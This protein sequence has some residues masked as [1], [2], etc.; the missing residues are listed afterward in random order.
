MEI[1]I[2]VNVLEPSI[3]K[4]LDEIHALAHLKEVVAVED[5][6]YYDP[7]RETLKPDNTYHIG[8]CFR[9]RNKEGHYYITYKVDRFDEN[10]VWLYSDEEE[11]DIG[12]IDT[13]VSIV[14]HLGFKELVRVTMKK[15]IFET[16]EHYIVLETVVGLGNFLEVESKKKDC[17][18]VLREREKIKE[19]IAQF[20][21]ET[22]EDAG[23]GK[24][25]LLLRKYGYQ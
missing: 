4:V 15:Y 2:L 11:T 1:E 7:L 8:E 17:S 21:F 14:N 19:L 18:D 10:G 25:E 23:A 6:Y 22:T 20:D 13:L 16:K 5:I 9:L 12:S 24:P 3:Q